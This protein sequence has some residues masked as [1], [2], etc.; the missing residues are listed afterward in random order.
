[1]FSSRSIFGMLAILE[2]ASL[3][4]FSIVPSSTIPTTG[5]PSTAELETTAMHFAAY[6]IY[7]ML[8]QKSL[9]NSKKAILAA[10]FLGVLT[11]IIQIF[12]PTRS[13]SATD[14]AADISGAAVGIAAIMLFT[15]RIPSA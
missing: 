4:Y 10:A 12:A 6:L 11:E 9:L 8:L 14:I 3:I 13:F 1:M 7:G 2:T 5:N 15:K